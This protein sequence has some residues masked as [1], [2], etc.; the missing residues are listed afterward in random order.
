MWP[1]D[2]PHR[3]SGKGGG[4]HVGRLERSWGKWKKVWKTLVRGFWKNVYVRNSTYLNPIIALIISV[5]NYRWY[6]RSF[7]RIGAGYA[8]AQPSWRV[9]HLRSRFPTHGRAGWYLHW[10]FLKGHVRIVHSIS[11]SSGTYS[12]SR[13]RHFKEAEV[14]LLRFQQCMTR[15][16][17]LIKMNFVGS[18]RA[19]SS[20]VTKRLS[21]K[22][23]S[24]IISSRTHFLK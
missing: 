3:Y 24:L 15:A 12:F 2:Q 13:K 21:E 14:Y 11:R 23:Y 22:V 19:L 10:F 1:F 20:E 9:S 7:P 8:N 5:L 18:L 6:R 16:M 17:T 4:W